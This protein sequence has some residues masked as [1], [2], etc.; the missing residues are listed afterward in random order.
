[1]CVSLDTSIA[2]DRKFQEEEG[3]LVLLSSEILQRGLYR[4][5]PNQKHGRRSG[6]DVMFSKGLI[7]SKIIIELK[8]VIVVWM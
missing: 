5:T 1:M 6:A 3:D 7:Y 2:S 8:I 4:G